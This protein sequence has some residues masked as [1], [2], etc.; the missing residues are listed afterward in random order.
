MVDAKAHVCRENADYIGGRYPY[1]CLRCGKRLDTEDM[2]ADPVEAP[3]PVPE[4]VCV[5]CRGDD[6]VPCAWCSG[7]RKRM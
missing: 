5:H 4:G 3:E 2:R 1:E 7:T 6:S